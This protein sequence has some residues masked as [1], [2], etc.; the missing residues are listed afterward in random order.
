LPLK[1]DAQGVKGKLLDL[2]DSTPLAGATIQLSKLK[3]STAKLKTVSDSKGFFRLRGL[4]ADSFLLK[5]S[6]VG[7]AEYRQFIAL[8]DSTADVDPGKLFMLT[9]TYNLKNF[10]KGEP[11][12]N[13]RR[14][15]PS[16]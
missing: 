13:Q 4:S 14:Q 11:V 3:D 16:F 7:Y 12:E 1:I 10:R 15:R 8:T 6:F 9:F 5:V 2:I